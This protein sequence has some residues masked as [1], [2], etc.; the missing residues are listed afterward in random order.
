MYIPFIIVAAVIIIYVISIYNDLQK[1]KTQIV[2]SIQEIGNQ[3][4]RQASLIPNLQATVK[5][6]LKHESSI[7]KMLTDARKAAEKAEQ[8][9][10]SKDIDDAIT[11]IQQAV[12]KL[13][14][15]VEDN[16]EMKADKS[17][18]KFMNELTD[19]ADKLMYARRSVIDLSQTYNQKLVIFPSNMIANMFGFKPEKGLATALTGSHVEVSTAETKDVK[20]EF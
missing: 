11:Q 8:T 12:P 10:S 5:G 3:L 2:A 4:K 13:T 15:A 14:I 17:V 18:A 16:P 7:F 20:V 6:Y 1:L 19:T 9:G